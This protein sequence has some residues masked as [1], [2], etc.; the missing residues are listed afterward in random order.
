MGHHILIVEDEGNEA[1]LYQEEFEEA[2]YDVTV[3]NNADAALAA[4]R[5]RRPDLVVLDINM[6]G[7]D[8]LDLL[9]ELL[10]IDHKLPVVL[11]TAYREYQDQFMSWA[12]AAYVVKSSD[13]T[14]LLQTV[15]NVLAGHSR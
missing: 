3:A 4:V 8:G 6:P 15:S 2:G 12:A 14:E 1:L 11:N 10:D 7:K 9:R 5:A 13:P